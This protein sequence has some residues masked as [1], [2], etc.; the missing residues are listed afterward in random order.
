MAK[1]NIIALPQF[2]KEIKQLSKKYISLPAD[3]A[4]LLSILE[5]NPATGESLGNNCYKI[6]MKVAAKRTGK[7]G[8]ARVIT[9]VK[10]V[11]A[12]CIRYQYMIRQTGKQ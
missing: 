9:C 7:S 6:R 1:I 11:D 8:G 12:K 2:Q 10:I 3:F 4:N 5:N